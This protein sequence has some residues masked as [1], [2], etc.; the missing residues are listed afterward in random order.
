[1]SNTPPFV[2]ERL[3]R[4]AGGLAHDFANSL[5]G[6]LGNL[7]LALMDLPEDSPVRQDLEEIDS[8]ARGAVE[9]VRRMQLYAGRASP[10]LVPL[11]LNALVAAEKARLVGIAK[12]AALELKLAPE[13]PDIS[14]DGELLRTVLAG[15]AANARDAIGERA[16]GRIRISTAW[17]DDGVR[18]EVTDDGDGMGEE[19]LERAFDPYFTTRPHRKGLSLA[20]ALG[21]VRAHNARIELDSAPGRGTTA[22]L[23]FPRVLR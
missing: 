14:G 5:G 17:G 15:L 1:M 3:R 23:I 12:G 4:L 8:A 10:I 11:S 6:I 16:A 19:V 2:E 18:L 20:V 13:L 7:Q 22:R 9:L 21:A